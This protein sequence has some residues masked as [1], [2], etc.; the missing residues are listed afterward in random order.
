MKRGVPGVPSGKLG[1]GFAMVDVGDYR[2]VTDMGLV[3]HTVYPPYLAARSSTLWMTCAVLCP[4]P[5]RAVR[6]SEF[7]WGSSSASASARI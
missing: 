7:S 6:A 3:K 1:K 2:K 4:T 5:G